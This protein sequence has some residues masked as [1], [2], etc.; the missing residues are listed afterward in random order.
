LGFPYPRPNSMWYWTRPGEYTLSATWQTSGPKKA[1][2]PVLVAPPI[3]LKVTA[4][5]QRLPVRVL[6]IRVEGLPGMRKEIVTAE[7]LA[8]LFDE[9]I[10]ALVKKEVD[11]TRE[12]L[13]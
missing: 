2:G 5:E 7:E 9:K 6:P 3:K 10:Q 12:K 4:A 11:F 1:G 8:K 13:V